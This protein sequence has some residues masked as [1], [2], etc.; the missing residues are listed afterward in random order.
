[1]DWWLHLVVSWLSLFGHFGGIRILKAWKLE[2]FLQRSAV[3]NTFVTLGLKLEKFYFL[4]VLKGLF[5]SFFFFWLF[6]QVMGKVQR[7]R[8]AQRTLL[9]YFRIFKSQKS[10]ILL[11]TKST[12]LLESKST[13][14]KFLFK[15][16]TFYKKGES[17]KY[18]DIIMIS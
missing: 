4:E 15:E 12:V 5:K 16:L 14:L 2:A 18:R 9:I 17:W 3:L 8:E 11:L 6:L 13:F 7:P 1:M 10:S